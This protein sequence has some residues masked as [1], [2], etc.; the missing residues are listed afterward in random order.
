MGRPKLLTWAPGPLAGP[1]PPH[2]HTLQEVASAFGPAAVADVVL[3]L[4]AE[5]DTQGLRL[6]QR[7]LEARRVPA[8]AADSARRGGGEGP[9]PR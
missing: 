7:F 4:Q 9:D 2:K 1:P 6:L 5:C 8:V 3:A